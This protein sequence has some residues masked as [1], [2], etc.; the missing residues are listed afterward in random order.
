MQRWRIICL[1]SALFKWYEIFLYKQMEQFLPPPPTCI[2]GYRPGRQCLDIACYLNDM[3]QKAFERKLP[4][5]VLA[6]D[7]DSAFDNINPE[8][9]AQTLYRQGCAG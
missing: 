1:A 8:V 7:I 6:M 5:A 3:M 2:V 4:E 9:A